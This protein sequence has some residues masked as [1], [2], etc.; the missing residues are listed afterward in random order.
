MTT[1]TLSRLLKILQTS[2]N[3]PARPQALLMTRLSYYLSIARSSASFFIL[4]SCR[5]SLERFAVSVIWQIS[6]SDG[7]WCILVMHF[8]EDI[9]S[10]AYPLSSRVIAQIEHFREDNDDGTRRLVIC[11]MD[12][13]PTQDQSYC[14]RPNLFPLESSLR[15]ACTFGMPLLLHPLVDCSLSINLFQ[16][17]INSL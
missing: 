4:S 17:P 10:V 13:T 1:T 8:S 16:H 7:P 3:L 14:L 5:L 2:L 6:Y 9:Q 11:I 12:S 15:L